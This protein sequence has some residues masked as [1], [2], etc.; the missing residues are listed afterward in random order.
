MQLVVDGISNMY[1]YLLRNSPFENL[2]LM[3]KFLKQLI[4]LFTF[5]IFITSC[6]SNDEVVVHKDANS[7][8]SYRWIGQG[9]TTLVFVHGWCADHSYWNNQAAYF[10]KN[11]KVL[12]LDL[13]GLGLTEE[14]IA[15]DYGKSVP[16][17]LNQVLDQPAVLVGHS[18]GVDIVLQSIQ[19]LGDKVVKW[20]VIDDFKSLDVEYSTEEKKEIDNIISN[21][22]NNFYRIGVT[23]AEASLLDKNSSQELY[24]K[25]V[26][27]IK[28]ANPQA[29]AQAMRTGFE[30]NEKRQELLKENK[31]MLHL[32]QS[33]EEEMDAEALTNWKVPYQI[34]KLKNAGHFPMVDK[35][36]AFNALLGKIITK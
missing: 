22:E 25:V 36:P 29:A 26:D 21:L 35:A 7:D 24:K 13:P 10:E 28:R 11:Y 6:Q 8:I 16:N 23:F 3:M 31:K 9:D 17:L 5:S 19:P 1:F 14:A 12:L 20:V 27:D 34:H 18:L 33:N 15:T 4:L 30:F 2:T 32:I